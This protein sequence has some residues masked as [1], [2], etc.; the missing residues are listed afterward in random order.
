MQRKHKIIIHLHHFQIRN[1]FF[2]KR[3][4]TAMCRQPPVSQS[5][6]A[7]KPPVHGVWFVR[8]HVSVRGISKSQHIYMYIPPSTRHSMPK[9]MSVQQAI[10]SAS[11]SIADQ[12]QVH[13]TRTSPRGKSVKCLCGRKITNLSYFIKNRFNDAVVG[14]LGPECV[15]KSK[16]E[17]LTT[18]TITSPTMVIET[19]PYTPPSTPSPP[20]SKPSP[21]ASTPVSCSVIH[22]KHKA[23]NDKRYRFCET[24]TPKCMK[25]GGDIINM[26]N[27]RGSFDSFLR[28]NPKAVNWMLNN[29]NKFVLNESSSPYYKINN[30]RRA[31]AFNELAFYHPDGFESSYS[32]RDMKQR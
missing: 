27:T 17:S 24:C 4:Q 22:C 32:R 26:S 20:P 21:P 6:A 12:W 11:V 10:A 30:F 18:H 28:S 3:A 16:C 25:A 8:A 23:T 19:T 29:H 1:R 31:Y 14:P 7:C 9:T 5:L 2:Q 15:G 13:E